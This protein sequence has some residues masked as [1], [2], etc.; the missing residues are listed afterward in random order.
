MNK[1]LVII[2]NQT[3]AHELT[4]NNFKKNVIDELNA[5]LCVCIGVSPHYNYDNPFYQLA[6]YRFC[7]NEPTG[8][9][10]ELFDIAYNEIISELEL[11]ENHKHWREFLKIPFFGWGIEGTTIKEPRSSSIQI[12]IRWFL[13]KN[14][15]NNGLLNKYDRFIVTR[16]DYMHRLPH[17]KMELMD[18]ENIWI[19][20]CE[21]YGGYTDRHAILSN[22]NISSYL[23]IFNNMVEKSSEFYD[24]MFELMSNKNCICKCNLESLLYLNIQYNKILMI[25]IINILT[26]NY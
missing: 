9:F 25:I 6:K 18:S 4:F 10:G 23:N 8:D 17:P 3:R 2:Y 1:T 19:P 14:L 24:K 20:D 16:S 15:I 13:L 12:Y 5:D 7:F 26:L 21:H 22:L 11:N